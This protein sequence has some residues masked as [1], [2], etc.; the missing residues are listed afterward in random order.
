VRFLRPV[1]EEIGTIPIS[2]DQISED[3]F[4]Q[5]KISRDQEE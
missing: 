4:S 5:D 1:L 2:Q 3:Q